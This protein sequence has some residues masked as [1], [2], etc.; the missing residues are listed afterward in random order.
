MHPL[1]ASP[2][3]PGVM[4][5]LPGAQ[6]TPARRGGGGG[7][8]GGLS[9]QTMLSP[10]EDTGSV[11]GQH[12]QHGHRTGVPVSSMWS[13]EKPSAHGAGYVGGSRV[14]VSSCDG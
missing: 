6:H 11:A 12:A 8:G 7:G 14:I 2:S 10:G 9:R 13:D 5:A 1:Q 4:D 3:A